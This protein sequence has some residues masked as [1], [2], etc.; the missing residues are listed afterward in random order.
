MASPD[1]LTKGTAGH[2]KQP[3]VLQ[4]GGLAEAGVDIHSLP[5]AHPLMGLQPENTES[6]FVLNKAKLCQHPVTLERGSSEKLDG[7]S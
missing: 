5:L 7:Y 1:P 3:S 6:P 4:R 2:G